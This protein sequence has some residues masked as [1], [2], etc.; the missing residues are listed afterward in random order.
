[1]LVITQ[2]KLRADRAAIDLRLEATARRVERSAG[3]MK[4]DLT[5]TAFTALLHDAPWGLLI[6]VLIWIA[7]I[8]IGLYR[9]RRRPQ[10]AP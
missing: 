1:M 6:A 7:L 3:S 4:Q 8:A 10:P 5:R 9:G 2:L